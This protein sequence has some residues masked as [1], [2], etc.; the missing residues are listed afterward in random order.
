LVDDF[1]HYSML[2]EMVENERG[3]IEV[4]IELDVLTNLGTRAKKIGCRYKKPLREY[5]LKTNIK[6]R[7]NAAK[8][9]T[10]F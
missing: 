5:S 7:N 1:E 6:I 4:R 3:K 10:F 9:I 2:G 8:K